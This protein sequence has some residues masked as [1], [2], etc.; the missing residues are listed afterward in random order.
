M[1][2]YT[3]KLAKYQKKFQKYQKKLIGGS[4]INITKNKDNTLINCQDKKTLDQVEL[5]LKK[6]NINN[7]KSES[8]SAYS[9]SEIYEQKPGSEPFYQTNN[10]NN[11]KYTITIPTNELITNS[12][13]DV[14]LKN[15]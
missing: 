6:Y 10:N 13:L 5:L 11:E 2:I 9:S 15:I 4:N 7:Y 3:Y 12:K 14:E 1:D 8:F